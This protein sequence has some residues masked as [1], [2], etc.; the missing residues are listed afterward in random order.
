[1][2]ISSAWAERDAILEV[3]G[4]RLSI[5]VKVSVRDMR[6]T[7]SVQDSES[8]VRMSIRHRRQLHTLTRTPP[9]LAK[10][11]KSDNE[12]IA[13][14]IGKPEG[15]SKVELLTLVRFYRDI[16]KEIVELMGELKGVV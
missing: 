7:S 13:F 5:A 3:E 14:I 8:R 15:H 6:W 11:A 10:N 4:D 12:D 2:S 16:F 1:M 9:K